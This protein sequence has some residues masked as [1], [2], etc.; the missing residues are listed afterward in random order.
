MGAINLDSRDGG[1]CIR[2]AAAGTHYPSVYY[3]KGGRKASQSPPCVSWKGG[4]AGYVRQVGWN[5][6]GRIDIVKLEKEKYPGSL[7][8]R[9][10]RTQLRYTGK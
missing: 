6:G 9:G 5:R 4:G 7:P 3:V 1:H 10:T 2:L 8:S